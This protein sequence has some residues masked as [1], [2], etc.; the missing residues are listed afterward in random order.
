MKY[1]L[2][3]YR[4]DEAR[5]SLTAGQREALE[6]ECLAAEIELRGNGRLVSAQDLGDGREAVSVELKQGQVVYS[7]G[8][9]PT[10]WGTLVRLLFVEAADL[11]DAMRA[12][13][14]LPQLR[15]GP[16]EVRPAAG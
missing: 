7:E 10:R 13:A 16:I 14:Q 5:L 15:L 11:N 4:D 8:P 12:A 6:R 2:L 3:A 9:Y 1:L